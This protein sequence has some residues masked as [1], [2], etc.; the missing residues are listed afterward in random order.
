MCLSITFFT[1]IYSFYTHLDCTIC[2]SYT[3]LVKFVLNYKS[4]CFGNTRIAN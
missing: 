3:K 1:V 2:L 4:L